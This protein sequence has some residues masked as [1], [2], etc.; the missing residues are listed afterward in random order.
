MNYKKPEAAQLSEML[1]MVLGDETEVTEAS[2]IDAG[3]LGYTALYANR[4]GETVASCCCPIATAAALGCALSMIPPGGAEGMVE[5]NELSKMASDNLYEV[6]NI[7]SSLMM[8]DKSAHLKLVSVDAGTDKR[9]TG[10]DFAEGAFTLD[11]GKYGSGE[12]VFNHS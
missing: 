4:D 6:M 8:N 3:K 7:F 5:D 1:T 2:A 12:L 9:L 11:L 10:D